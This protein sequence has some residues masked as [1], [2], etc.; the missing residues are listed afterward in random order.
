M[1]NGFP[2]AGIAADA[3][4]PGTIRELLVA[5]SPSGTG[6]GNDDVLIY[7]NKTSAGSETVDVIGDP[8]VDLADCIARFGRRS[9]V[10]WMYRKF[11]AIP[12]QATV[13][14]VAVTEAGTAA[15]RTYTFATAA[16]GDSSVK[17]EWGGY[18]TYAAITSGDTAITVAAAVNSA[19]AAWEGGDMPFTAAVG[20]GGSEHIV[21]VTTAN[22]GD[23]TQNILSR[24]RMTFTK[25]VAMTV[26]TGAVGGGATADD[27]TA[28]YAQA[29]LGTFAWQINP[30]IDASPTTTDNGMGEGANYI[31]TQLAPVNGKEQFMF[32]GA[33]STNANARTQAIAL[34]NAW[35]YLVHAENNPWTPGMLAAHHCAVIRAKA[36]AHPG[37]NLTGYQAGGS[38]GTDIYQVPRPYDIG[39]YPTSTEIETALDNGVTPIKFDQ[40]GKP[41]LVRDVTTR[42]LLSSGVNDYRARE[43]HIPRVLR[44]F[45]REVSNRWY[46]QKQPFVAEDPKQGQKPLA[47]MTY[48]SSV[49]KLL[50][51]TMTDMAGAWIG[52]SPVLDPGSLDAMV[53]SCEALKI[54]GGISAKANPI[55]VIHNNKQQFLIGESSPAY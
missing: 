14:A 9:E 43:G 36:I 25:T 39:D 38:G 37:A 19:I 13:Y 41:I 5:Q 4:T 2:I 6:G 49:K 21:T 55:A 27:F 47:L 22:T 20:G 23:R 32:F 53:A 45:W 30:K 15:T 29:A 3:A 54:Q 46:A 7:G 11:I 33:V 44:A 40:F 42:S 10:T 8:I 28:A 48:P 34:N 51:D 16:T 18:T 1:A 17:I 31:T 52:G 12:Q 50:Q 24:L 35:C 26:A